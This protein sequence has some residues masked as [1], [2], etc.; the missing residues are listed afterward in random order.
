MEDTKYFQMFLYSLV[1]LISFLLSVIFLTSLSNI[2]NQT[3]LTGLN[4]MYDSGYYSSKKYGK[5]KSY[6]NSY[7]GIAV[8]FSFCFFGFLGF[9]AILMIIVKQYKINWVDKERMKKIFQPST[10]NENKTGEDSD[11]KMRNYVQENTINVIL[12]EKT[13]SIDFLRK[14]MIFFYIYCQGIYLIEVMVLTAY[15]SVAKDLEKDFKKDLGY[16]G[17]K[18]YTRIYRDLITVGY[19]FLVLFIVFDLYT[20]ILACGKKGEIR[21]E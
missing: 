10:D 7:I 18:F 15:F 11:E 12:G 1:N 6:H 9:M 19:I 8:L 4:D 2:V 20:L 16:E 17:G 14:I 5:Y 21:Y 3:K 13:I